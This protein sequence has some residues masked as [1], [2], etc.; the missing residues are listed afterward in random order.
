[1]LAPTHRAFAV[2]S[3]SATVATLAYTTNIIAEIPTITEGLST[4]IPQV[5]LSTPVPQILSILALLIVT[6]LTATLPDIDQYIPFIRHRGIT[7]AIWIPLGL[8]Y[9][10]WKF[11]NPQTLYDLSRLILLSGTFIGY[12]SHI[13]GDAFSSAGIAWFYPLQRYADSG[14]GAFYVKG[15]RGPFLPLYRVGQ[16]IFI[17]P[18]IIWYGISIML[19]FI[20]MQK[21]F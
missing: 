11:W 15:F 20:T 4:P 17:N 5:L 6:F 10:V 9:L 18:S 1:M 21:I 8:G 13:I 3:A 19:L 14:T 2:A 12:T 7:H 16:D